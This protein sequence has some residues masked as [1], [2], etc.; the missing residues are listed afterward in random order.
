[1]GDNT[2]PLTLAL[3]H[4]ALVPL[5]RQI[6]A[7]ALVALEAERAKVDGKLAYSEPEAARLLDLQPWVLRG[8]RLRGRISA[9]KIV[10]RRIRYLKTDLIDYMVR[11]RIGN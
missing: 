8:E 7:E 2:S 3:D 5:V 11:R 10:G 9:S 4:T 6:V 1:M